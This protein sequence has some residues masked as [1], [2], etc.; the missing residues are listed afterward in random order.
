MFW[1]DSLSNPSVISPIIGAKG[2]TGSLTLDHEDGGIDI[3]DPSEGLMYQVWTGTIEGDNIVLRGENG[4]SYTL[5][6]GS[7]VTEISFSFDQN[8]EPVIVYVK[9]KITKFWWYDS[10][11]PGYITTIYGDRYLSPKVFLDDKRL[12]ERSLSDIIF[13]YVKPDT[14][15]QD[16]FDLWF[17]KQR[18]RY[19]IE[20]RLKAYAGGKLR[21]LGMGHNLRLQFI[22]SRRME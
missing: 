5:N 17:R 7:G 20:Y 11:T 18:D 19:L 13:A 22:F 2:L 16:R 6:T 21:H 14:Q 8:M 15:N 10:S 4:N 9:N 3:G 12:M 1:E